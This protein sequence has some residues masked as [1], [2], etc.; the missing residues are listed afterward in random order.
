[1]KLPD[2]YNKLLILNVYKAARYT[3]KKTYLNHSIIVW[4]FAV[5]G[6]IYAPEKA[7][8]LMLINCIQGRF[9]HKMRHLP[10]ALD[11]AWSHDRNA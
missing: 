9:G 4:R 10:G 7:T 2:Y 6:L 8:H 11:A 3:I 5:Q 1:L